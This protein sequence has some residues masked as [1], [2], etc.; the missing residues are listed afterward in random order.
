MASSLSPTTWNKISSLSEEN[1]VI[2]GTRLN[3]SLEIYYFVYGLVY[4]TYQRQSYQWLSILCILV[5]E[6]YSF[7]YVVAWKVLQPEWLPR[8]LIVLVTGRPVSF[9]VDCSLEHS[10]SKDLLRYISLLCSGGR[11]TRDH[12]ETEKPWYYTAEVV[13][14]Q[15]Q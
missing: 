4:I 15:I 13:Y 8:P 9:D 5:A 2:Y 11:Q 14:F 10:V 7:H 1:V 3:F 12:P 6:D